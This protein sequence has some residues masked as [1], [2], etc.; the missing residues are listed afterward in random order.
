MARR[1]PGRAPRRTVTVLLLALAAA[2]PAGCALGVQDQPV[3]VNTAPSAAAD[4]G[5][6]PRSATVTTEVT[7]FFAKGEQL[8]SLPRTVPAGPGLQP[9]LAGLLGPLSGD[10]TDA[11]LRSALPPGTKTLAVDVRDGVAVVTMPPGL[12][13]LPISQQ[14]LAVAQLVFTVTANSPVVG[15][16]L[17]D[18][19]RAVDVPNDQ[20]RLVKGPVSR[21]DYAAVV[22]G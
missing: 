13:R 22:G 8:V 6:P 4:T 18:G 9:A 12:D 2:T 21:T 10:D 20:G 11:G 15:L 16:Q 19:E 14:I 3:P 7:V 17:T 1:A 5:A